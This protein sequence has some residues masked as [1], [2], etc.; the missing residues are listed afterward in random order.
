MTEYTVTFAS[1]VTCIFRDTDALEHLCSD[2][3]KETLR[4]VMLHAFDAI[5][6]VS[7]DNVKV[8]ISKEDVE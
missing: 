3:F 6:D 4:V 2:E 7:V 1:E 5:H 8:F